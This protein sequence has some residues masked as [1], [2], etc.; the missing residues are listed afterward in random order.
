MYLKRPA[1]VQDAFF[2]CPHCGS[3]VPSDA[4][5][6]R[7]CGAD[8]DCGWNEDEFDNHYDEFD[9]D[10]FDYDRFVAEEFPEQAVAA[11]QPW[12]GAVVLAVIISLLLTLLG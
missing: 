12:L 4:R 7:E 6:C 10:D 9:E 11:P 3:P 1:V 5:L 2:S 8:E